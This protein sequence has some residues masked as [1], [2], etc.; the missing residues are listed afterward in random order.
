MCCYTSWSQKSA[1]LLTWKR[2]SFFTLVFGFSV[3]S[4]HN[5]P[6]KILFGCHLTK[7]L[8][9][10]R[11]ETRDFDTE[12]L[13]CT[14]TISQLPLQWTALNEPTTAATPTTTAAVVVVETAMALVYGSSGSRYI[15]C[16]GSTTYVLKRWIKIN[17]LLKISANFP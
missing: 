11:V 4:M 2:V 5:L 12:K 13:L 14:K 9:N 6:T 7:I 10:I 1:H 3:F 17:V 8:S 16:Y 15:R